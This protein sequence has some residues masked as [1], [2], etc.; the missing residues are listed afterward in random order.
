MVG[1]QLG[2]S[3]SPG[4]GIQPGGGGG[5]SGQ[6]SSGTALGPKY[7]IRSALGSD[8]DIGQG[9]SQ[10]SSLVANSDFVILA[11]YSKGASATRAAFNSS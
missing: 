6:G 9:S 2:G 3:G 5:R 7:W 10:K 4:V 11:A 1:G 8:F